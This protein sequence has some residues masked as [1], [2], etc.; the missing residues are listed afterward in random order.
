MGCVHSIFSVCI[1][2]RPSLL[3]HLQCRTAPAA[4]IVLIPGIYQN[5]V[6]HIFFRMFSD[7][8]QNFGGMGID[9]L[10]CSRNGVMSPIISGPGNRIFKPWPCIPSAGN[11]RD[12]SDA[13]A[14]LIFHRINRPVPRTQ[15]PIWLAGTLRAAAICTDSLKAIIQQR[16]KDC[17]ISRSRQGNKI[18]GLLYSSNR[19]FLFNLFYFFC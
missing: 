7:F 5:A 2:K 8:P 12:H 11:M 15:C 16:R 6:G 1:L 17:R 14:V 4:F 3:I 9:L 10:R 13:V 18:N 19:G